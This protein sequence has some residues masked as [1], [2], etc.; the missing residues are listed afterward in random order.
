MKVVAANRRE[1]W[2]SIAIVFAAVVVQPVPVGFA[3]ALVLGGSVAIG[4]VCAVNAVL[5]LDEMGVVET[6]VA[7]IWLITM[8]ILTPL[9]FY[10]LSAIREFANR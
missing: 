1:L 4:L 8:L 2:V 7:V 9:I 3:S 6:Y 5:D 10:W